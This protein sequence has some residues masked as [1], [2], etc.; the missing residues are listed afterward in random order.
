MADKQQK[1]VPIEKRWENDYQ[2]K[3]TKRDGTVIDPKEN[4]DA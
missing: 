2:P 4:S 3:I 1:H